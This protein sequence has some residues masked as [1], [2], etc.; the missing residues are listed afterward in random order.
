MFLSLNKKFFS[1]IFAFFIL[2]ASIFL[3]VLDGTVGEKMRTDYNNIMKRN[4]Y[5]IALLN[6]NI[7]LRKK[8]EQLEPD[9]FISN[10]KSLS[11]KQEELSKERQLNEELNKNY[12]D[13]NATLIEILKI[14]GLGALLTFLSL[15]VFGLLLR[16]WVIT[17]VDKLTI[18]S[19]A[20]ANGDFSNRLKL[21]K[22]K[23]TDE[24]DTLSSTINFMLDSIEEQIKEIKEKELYLQNLI[25]AIPDAVRIIDED[26][27]IT[28]SNKTYNEQIR[29]KVFFKSDKCYGS[30]C[31]SA[32]APCNNSQ[33]ICPLKELKKSKSSSLKL[34]HSVNNKPL[35]I[36]SARINING[37][38][39]IVESIRDLSENINYSHQQKISSLGFL[40]T[41]IAHEMK[42]NLGAIN[43]ILDGL[44]QKYF[45]NEDP[46]N[47]KKQYLEMISSQIK[48]CI[49][50][51]ERLLK[52]SRNTEQSETTFS[53]TSSISDILSL[54]DYEIKSKGII[55]TK[56]FSNTKETI[57]GNET[58][59]K[60]IILNLVQNAI[61]A[62]PNGG[63]LE[64]KTNTNK[65]D[66]LISIKDN[67]CGIP[68][69][70][71]KHIFEP[72]Y[73]TSNFPDKKGTGLG[74]A[75]VKDLIL[76]LNAE[77]DVNSKEN[78]GSTFQIA[79]PRQKHQKKLVK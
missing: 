43:M 67:G 77:I 11:E 6:E 73:S 52:I 36:N 21:K 32:S 4:Q 8:I 53:I 59:F 79:I 41:S 28:L 62:M 60:M 48:E 9:A 54:L 5:V 40:A 33:Y 78:Q 17:P 35:S 70:D 64:I 51:P 38:Y 61:N 57:Y 76:K 7:I 14:I 29:Q 75:I 16:F 66:I 22:G 13:K 45:N 2:S 20:V 56:N 27:N 69:K 12:N 39:S 1:I 47:E 3:L 49:K 46:E 72:F 26:Y 74:L 58:D 42:N 44:L 18:L 37:K 65:E 10:T 15:I 55:L 31:N 71:I 24:F 30:Y 63:K 23:F 25:D 34:I 19:I 68:Q 50:V